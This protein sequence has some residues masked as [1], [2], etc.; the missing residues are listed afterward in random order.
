MDKNQAFFNMVYNDAIEAGCNHI[1]ASVCA[2]QCILESNWG[3]TLK[4]NAYFGIKAGKSW[5]GDTQTFTTHEVVNGKRIKIQDKFRAYD[6]FTDSVKDYISLMEKNFP[7][8][9]NA[10][11]LK[12][13]TDGLGHGKYGRYATDPSYEKKIYATI[14]TRSTKVTDERRTLRRGDKGQDVNRLLNILHSKGYYDGPI[15]GAFG[16][17]TE[18]A[19]EHFQRDAGLKADGIVGKQTYEALEGW[20]K[21]ASTRTL[22][23]V[24]TIVYTNQQAIRNKKC[25]PHLEAL[26]EKAL[27]AV[28]GKGVTGRIYSGG[29][30][31]KGKG[32]RRT[33]SVRHD[34][35]KAMD[36]HIFDA[37]GNQIV[38]IE[39]AKLGQ[40]WIAMG[41]GSCGLE[42]AGGGIHLDQWTTPPSGGALSWTY[43]ASDAKSYGAEVKQ[44][45]LDGR[46]GIKPKLPKVVKSS[47]TGTNKKFP[48]KEVGSGVVI[49]GLFWYWDRLKE[50]LTNLIGWLGF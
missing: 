50:D 38:G 6:S 37:S 1:Q 2:G 25:T 45:L 28:Y 39:L 20:D 46:K 19:V 40:Y 10:K 36:A 41:Y 7:A 18:A 29:Q 5:K 32:T 31:A 3:K 30:D 24:A 43:K 47:S 16:G 13:A 14:K 9:W 27:V 4:G 22:K 11:T 15:D 8:T 49:I 23:D 35:G 12:E 42:M 48:G 34:N 44:M 26:F 21:D 33:G 17:G